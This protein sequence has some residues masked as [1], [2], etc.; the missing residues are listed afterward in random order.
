MSGHTA[1]R[2]WLLEPNLGLPAPSGSVNADIAAPGHLA[3]MIE[4]VS[5]AGRQR[6]VAR[7]QGSFCSGPCHSE[8]WA[9]DLEGQAKIQS[10]R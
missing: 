10:C 9:S 3:G 4:W 5:R 6:G 1:S 8:P 7:P 2:W